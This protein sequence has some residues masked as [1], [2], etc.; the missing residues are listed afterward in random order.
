MSL[1]GSC[2]GAAN[3]A[4]SL[5]VLETA[6]K[7]GNSQQALRLCG[8]TRLSGFV[9]DGSR[10][11]VIIF[12]EVDPAL[13]RLYLDDFVVALRSVHLAYA[14]KSGRTYYYSPPGCS[15]DPDP[16]TLRELQRVSEK[17]SGTSGLEERKQYVG[18]WNA[19]GGQAQKVRV[20]GAPFNSR[21]AKVMVDADYYM[22][23]LV[24]GSVDLGIDGFRSLMDMG[25]DASRKELQGGKPG[26]A[27]M[28]TLNRFWFCPGESTFTDEDGATMLESCRVKLLT[29]NQF[30]T[31]SGLAASGSTDALAQQFASDFTARY[32][33]I[34]SAKPIYRELEGLFRFVGLAKLIKDKKVFSAAGFRAR[35]LMEGY[36]IPYVPVPAT[37]PGLTNSREW[38]A[39]EE[40]TDGYV[41][42]EMLHVCCGGVSMDVRPKPVK[43]AKKATSAGRNAGKSAGGKRPASGV[44]KAVLGSRKS[45]D[46][47]YWDFPKGE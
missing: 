43:P 5:R 39:R 27:E 16:K 1:G 20:M 13:P 42:M 24:N 32:G 3:R 11:D 36:R 46:S 23:R 38:Q 10:H 7:A 18:E 47:L 29:E 40:T 2:T 14:R 28:N 19:V 34:G 33:A 21:F 45:A 8:I 25:M 6:V 15:I 17:M 26:A 35:Y 9:V 41:S 31:L 30:L 37:L 44:K 4:V 22:K 12:G